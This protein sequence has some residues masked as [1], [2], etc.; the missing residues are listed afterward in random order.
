MYR[1]TATAVRF[2]K[3]KNDALLAWNCFP[4]FLLSLLSSKSAACR[5]IG[6]R[7]ALQI[8]GGLY[9]S[10]PA[11]ASSAREGAVTVDDGQR[12]VRASAAAAGSRGAAHA[13]AAP[14]HGAARHG[15]RPPAPPHPQ[16]GP[17]AVLRRRRGCGRR[18]RRGVPHLLLRT[19]DRSSPIPENWH[20]PCLFS[21]VMIHS[22]V[23]FSF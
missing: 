17:R 5:C 12:R 2:Q 9:T 10:F 8:R 1:T 7:A 13:A 11:P 16:R 21:H 22:T 6:C 14:R 20:L 4:P 3:M 18:P 19:Y 15:R 23:R